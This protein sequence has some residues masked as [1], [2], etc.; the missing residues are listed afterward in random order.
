MWKLIKTNYVSYF[1]YMNR[2][3]TEEIFSTMSLGCFLIWYRETLFLKA[4]NSGLLLL[5]FLVC[6]CLFLL[7]LFLYFDIEFPYV[8]LAFLELPM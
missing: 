8:A 1:L 2:W 7:F 6:F 3:K 5:L 4:V